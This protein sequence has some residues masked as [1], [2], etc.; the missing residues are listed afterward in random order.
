MRKLKL[1][2]LV[3]GLLCSC[4]VIWKTKH[5]G[6]GSVN[7]CA[8]VKPIVIER[9]MSEEAIKDFIAYHALRYAEK[10]WVRGL[11]LTEL[12][13]MVDASFYCADRFPQF[14]ESD[15]LERAVTMFCYGY[16]ETRWTPGS[17]C[18]NLPGY[19][20]GVKHWSID[21]FWTGLNEHNLYGKDSVFLKA[22]KLQKAGGL[23]GIEL[24][25]PPSQKKFEA[26]K[27][28]YIR[29]KKL[30]IKPKDMKF[31]FVVHEEGYD[32]YTSALVYRIMEELE[33]KKFGWSYQPYS[34][35]AKRYLMRK[36]KD[37]HIN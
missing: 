29:Q 31:N 2:L 17:V 28:E 23:P 12:R 34:T 35:T 7:P 16:S 24:M 1:G 18:F 20:P 13:K 22:M 4:L 14:W 6:S 11:R 5:P 32:D 25:W 8:D 30:K 15:R 37:N 10:D 33:R 19:T 3:L 26:A 21:V 36:L 9:Q 27:R